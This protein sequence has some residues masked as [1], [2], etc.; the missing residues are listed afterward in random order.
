MWNGIFSPVFTKH[1][2]GEHNSVI[3][4]LRRDYGEDSVRTD[5]KVK[6]DVDPMTEEVLDSPKSMWV[7]LVSFGT[8]TYEYLIESEDEPTDEQ[9]ETQL[10]QYIKNP[11]EGGRH[12]EFYLAD[13]ELDSE[14]E[15]GVE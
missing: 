8:K 15:D 13:E 6:V 10:R 7:V 14:R 11:I 4:H 9:I 3:A 12:I 2:D 5:R 1:Y